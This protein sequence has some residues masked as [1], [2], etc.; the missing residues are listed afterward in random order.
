MQYDKAF[1]HRLPNCRKTVQLELDNAAK[2]F[3]S[4]VSRKQRHI[5]KLSMKLKEPVDRKVLQSA[6]NATVPRFPSIAARLRRGMFWYWLESVDQAPSVQP[7]SPLQMHGMS[8]AELKQC[9]F[10]VLYGE[11]TVTVVFFHGICDGGGAMIF[12]KTLMAEY[13]EK[14]YQ[15][16]IP[17]VDG[18]LN[19]KE[20]PQLREIEDCYSKYAGPRAAK[21]SFTRAYRLSGTVEKDGSL[22]VI[23]MTLDITHILACAKAHDLS[24]TEFLAASMT[25]AILELQSERGNGRPVRPVLLA[26]P[27][28]LRNIFVCST[29]R[30]FSLSVTVGLDAHQGQWSFEQA[31]KRI[32]D[33]MTT[34]V[35]KTEMAACV[36]ANVKIEHVT[37][38]KW[39][40]LFIKNLLLKGAYSFFGADS[41][42][43]SL[44]NMGKI[45][46]PKEMS[47]F[48]T[49]VSC[50]MDANPR[51][52][53]SSAVLSYGDKLYINFARSIRETE[54]EQ[55][56]AAILASK[57]LKLCLEDQ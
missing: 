23:Q 14:K 28:N 5:Y 29:L 44:S 57:G 35:T 39:L 54:L 40:P 50:C 6:L 46:F 36:A 21:R 1:D 7:E 2:I 8:K 43:L 25:M 19:R 47:A 12:F 56:F 34:L 11:Y 45:I 32:H 31:G 4:T 9:C 33:Q 15:I 37:T 17:C 55:R 51:S 49:D 16:Q 26:I 53:N 48:I 38:F 3:S 42:C 27:V 41:C 52:T 18:I 10:R 13:L 22:H 24:L 20:S 30:N